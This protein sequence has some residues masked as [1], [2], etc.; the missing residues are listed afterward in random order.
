MAELCALSLWLGVRFS[1]IGGAS[2]VNGG[3]TS[4]KTDC[5]LEVSDMM[6]TT[7]CGLRLTA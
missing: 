2:D 6:L 3:L 1:G 5:T 4:R 7:G